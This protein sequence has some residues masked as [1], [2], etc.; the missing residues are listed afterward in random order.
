VLAIVVLAVGLLGYGRGG[1]A[2]ASVLEGVIVDRQD[3]SITLQTADRLERVVI[4]ADAVLK[5]VSGASIGLDRLAVGEVVSIKVRRVAGEV[6][7]RSI[8]RLED[9]L[10][11]WCAGN[12]RCERVTDR[13]EQMQDSCRD[14][15]AIDC[16]RLSGVC[17][18]APR[19]CPDETL[20]TPTPE[21]RPVLAPTSTQ[22]TRVAPT[23]TAVPEPTQERLSPTQT[24]VPPSSTP[25]RDATEARPTHTPEPTATQAQPTAEPTRQRTPPPSR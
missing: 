2:E 5:D 14:G 12:D 19:L 13:L 15:S 11:D 18:H 1:T 8:E 20:P 16:R 21:P 9:S 4:P 23:P 24:R 25:L 6:R 17:D 10:E 22:V 3:G 7:A